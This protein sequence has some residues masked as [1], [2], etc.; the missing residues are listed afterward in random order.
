MLNLLIV[1]DESAI[2]EGVAKLFPWAELGIQVVSTCRNGLEALGYVS[3]HRVDLVLCDIRMPRM[4]WPLCSTT[5]MRT[6][7]ARS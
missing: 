3:K 1:E 7:K 4:R 5:S 6:P 2:R